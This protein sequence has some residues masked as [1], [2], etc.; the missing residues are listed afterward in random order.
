MRHLPVVRK[1]G[2]LTKTSKTST[3]NRIN[4]KKGQI[5]KRKKKEAK[6]FKKEEH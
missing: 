1:K 5:Q 2:R 6:S 3:K 4:E